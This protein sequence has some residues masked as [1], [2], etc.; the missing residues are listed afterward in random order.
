MR[1]ISKSSL[2]A[3]V[4]LAQLAQF[5][6]VKPRTSPRDLTT[7]SQLGLQMRRCDDGNE[8]DIARSNTEKV[9]PDP[10]ERKVGIRGTFP[11]Y[12]PKLGRILFM[13]FHDCM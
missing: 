3:S 7:L 1:L 9:V 2:V 6:L 8:A 13:R 11:H 12:A 4:L 10:A 5:S